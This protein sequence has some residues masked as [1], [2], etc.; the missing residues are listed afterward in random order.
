LGIKLVLTM[1]YKP[2][3]IGK[4]KQGHAP[5]V[6]ALVKSCDG[7]LQDWPRLL[8]FV[9]W[10]DCTTRSTVTGY[11]PAELMDGKKPAMP[12]EEVV[13]IWS[14]L[15]QEDGLSREELLALQ[16]RQLERRPRNI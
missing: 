9:L 14:V 10:A 12:I 15:L 4:N 1:A 7:K 6:K 11:M 2:E 8:P 3:G 13:H 16:I 5:I